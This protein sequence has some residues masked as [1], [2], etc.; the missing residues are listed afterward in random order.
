M[1]A[2]PSQRVVMLYDRLSLDLM[3]AS[4]AEDVFTAGR[5]VSHAMEV[6]AEL[7]SRLSRPASTEGVAS[8]HAGRRTRVK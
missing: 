5:N 4:E 2:T 6:V 8:P 1:T 3:R 7:R